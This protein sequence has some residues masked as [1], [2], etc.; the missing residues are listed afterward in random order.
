MCYSKYDEEKEKH[1]EHEDYSITIIKTVFKDIIER[2]PINRN[3]GIRVEDVTALLGDK[4]APVDLNAL[5]WKEIISGQL[6]ADRADYLLRD[7]LHLGVNYGLYDKNRLINCITIGLNDA[8]SPTL[9]ISVG[10]WHIAES[11]VIARYQM[12]CQ[13]YFHKTRRIYDYHIYNAMKAILKNTQGGNDCY[14]APD[15]INDY[16]KLDDWSIM[17]YIKQGLGEE[18]GSIILN[19]NHYKCIFESDTIP[20]ARDLEKISQLEKEHDG[21]FYIDRA[22]TLWYKIDKDIEVWDDSN[23]RSG[24]LVPL[25]VKSSIVKSMVSKATQ[26]RFYIK[27]S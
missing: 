8:G 11:L 2:H 5:L 18:H 19:R 7:S 6:D 14:P 3:Y 23:G 15:H 25:S 27:R 20:T 9:A 26:I 10:G 4:Q 12:F 1:Y 22:S 16:L 13:V 24:N 17:G 21:T